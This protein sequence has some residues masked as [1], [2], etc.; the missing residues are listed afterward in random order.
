MHTAKRPAL[1]A[2]L[3]MLVIAGLLAGAGCEDSDPVNADGLTGPENDPVGNVAPETYLTLDLPPGVLPDTS[4]SRKLISWWGED[5]DG[6][7]VAYNYR[8]GQIQ[9]D[10][11]GEEPLPEDTLWYDGQWQFVQGESVQWVETS[12]EQ[13]EFVLP[14]RTVSATF[15]LEVSAVD[16]DGATDD[17]PASIAFPVINSRPEITFRLGSNPLSLDDQTFYTFPVRSFVWD[18]TDP[19]GNESIDKI[20]YAINPQPGDTAWQELSGDE[21]SITLQGLEP[22]VTTFWA[23]ARDVA[24][25]ESDLIHFPDSTADFDPEEWVVK[26]PA[27]GNDE[28]V[29]YLL[30]DD[31]R[32]DTQNVHLDFY[33]DCMENLYGGE[34]GDAYSTWELGEELPYVAADI[35]ETLLLFDRVLWFS[36]QGTPLLT[37]AFN[38]MYSFMNS[39]DGSGVRNR[40]MLLTTT[41]VDTGD[42]DL[43]DGML[44]GLVDT[45]HEVTGRLRA[46]IE[47]DPVFL[48]P[49]DN[50][51]V[52]RMQLRGTVMN[53]VYGIH[54]TGEGQTLYRLDPS[55][56]T[57]AQYEGEPIVGVR[58]TDKSY[59]L[60]SVPLALM[61][62]VDEVSQL[63]RVT[64]DE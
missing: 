54:V 14:I 57:P 58:R 47:E 53:T 3:L 39:T 35:T 4:R 25:F 62:D 32:F 64:F 8:W 20:L 19:D 48:E 44:L 24:G 51:D 10:L 11:S 46:T 55:T 5:P 6:R 17:Q 56:T 60:I 38:S 33:R 45:I 21:S 23:K 2:G 52:P 31:Y 49:Q 26:A 1:L 61:D 37:N 36:Y 63:I 15:V 59:T 41:T 50:A 34:E 27:A 16:N 12:E 22:G 28:G 9:Y 40:R 13:L 43:N 7:V 42:G 29:N 30:V 18:A